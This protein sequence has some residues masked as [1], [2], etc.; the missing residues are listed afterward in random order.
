MIEKDKAEV[1]ALNKEIERLMARFGRAMKNKTGTRFTAEEVQTLMLT[2]IG[3]SAAIC[4]HYSEED[5][6][7]TND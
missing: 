2:A 3:E 1:E 7:A 4:L 5:R 6:E